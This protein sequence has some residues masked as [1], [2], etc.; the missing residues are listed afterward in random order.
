V[1]RA[2]D[3]TAGRVGP[4]VRTRA[5]R[6]PPGLVAAALLVSAIVILPIV[7][8]AVRASEADAGAWGIVF[9]SRTAWLTA[10]SAGLAAAVTGAAGVLGVALAWLTTRTDLPLRRVW[11]VVLALP[12]VIPSY[13]GAFA[14]LAALGPRGMVQGALEG[15]FGIERLPD[16][17]GFT[18]AFVALTLFTYPYVYLLAAAAMRGVDPSLEEAARGLGCSR[19]ETFRRVTLPLLRPSVMAGALLVALYTLHDFGAVSLMRFQALTQAIYLQYRGAFDRTPAAMLSLL[20][21]CLA[22]AVLAME[23]RARGRARYFRSGAGTKRPTTP[24]R[25]GRRRWIA[26]SF[27]ALVALAALGLPIAVILYWLVRGVSAGAGVEVAWGAAGSSVA[28]AAGGALLAL[29]AAVPIALFSARHPGRLS[30]ATERVSYFGYA[31]PGLVVALAFVFFSARVTPWLYQSLPLVLAAYVVMFLPQASEPLRA[32]LLQIGPRIEEAGRALGRSRTRVF[33]S[34]TAPLISRGALAGL[35]LVFLTA[36]K[37]LPA[38]LLLRPTGFETLATRVWTG[39]AAGKY[40]LAAPP[41]LLLT[42]LCAVPLYV[43][44]RAVEV[45][46]TEVNPLDPD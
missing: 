36:M 29:V 12:L 3:L 9:R 43:L 28:V 8:L 4:V 1:S 15:P 42:L 26:V 40:S 19:W 16:I 14:L 5:V 6:A 21:V 41:A 37:E 27:C 18:G 2:A 24:I 23:Y 46:R 32:A 20:L 22:A 17:S 34:L 33:V 38:T 30:A 35:A 7:Y 45:R 25:L 44:V 11:A 31:L 13:V 39:A 10:R